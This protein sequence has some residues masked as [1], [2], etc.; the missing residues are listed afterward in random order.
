MSVAGQW[1]GPEWRAAMGPEI[2]QYWRGRLFLEPQLMDVVFNKAANGANDMADFKIGDRVIIIKE[3]AAAVVTK[4][5]S[6]PGKKQNQVECRRD[7]NGSVNDY[8][9]DQVRL[10]KA[11]AVAPVSEP[12]QPQAP[13][14][15]PAHEPSAS[16]KRRL[17]HTEAVAKATR[18]S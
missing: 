1:L 5:A 7:D 4:A 13:A 15:E 17:A 6:V 12:V 16:E 18:V 11:A 8:W 9:C 14:P 3:S 10:T 2:E